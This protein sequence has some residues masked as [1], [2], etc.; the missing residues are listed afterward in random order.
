M[1]NPKNHHV[2]FVIERHFDAEPAR[3]FAAWADPAAK[4]KWFVDND[5]DA[6]ETLDY[7]L[8]FRV[9]GREHGQ[10]RNNGTTV[11]GNETVY[12]DV[13]DNQRI[14]FAYTMSLD[15]VR[16]SASLTTVDLRPDGR[17]TELVFTEQAVFF[18]DLDEAGAREGGWRWLLDQL[19]DVLAA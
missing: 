6:W 9:G 12:L 1:Q 11:H 16:T 15:G 2:T 19:A 4:R 14:V 7:G 10:F 17:G 8:E 18:D 3:V 5:G 13:V